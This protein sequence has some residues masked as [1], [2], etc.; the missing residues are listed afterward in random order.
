MTIIVDAFQ[1][2]VERN[3][4]NVQRTL[5]Q[6]DRTLCNGR[7]FKEDS[8]KGKGLWEEMGKTMSKVGMYE[9]FGTSFSPAGTLFAPVLLLWK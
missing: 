3:C 2:S 4:Q 1:S 7:D 6:R 5:Y 8:V 9:P